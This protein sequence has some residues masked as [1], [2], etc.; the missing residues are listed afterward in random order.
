MKNV[1]TEL[2][3]VLGAFR[4]HLLA[5]DTSQHTMTA[6]LFD[7]RQFVVWHIQAYQDFAL[8]DVTPT[9]IRRYREELQEQSPMVSAATIDRRLSSLLTF[10]R[11]LGYYASLMTQA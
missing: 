5:E 7:V 3:V 8:A 1:S 6:Y 9:D 4:E 10:L 2:A 11:I